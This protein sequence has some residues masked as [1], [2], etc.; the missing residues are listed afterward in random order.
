VHGGERKK[1]VRW[2][3]SCHVHMHVYVG[4]GVCVFALRPV[5]TTHSV[6]VFCSPQKDIKDIIREHCANVC[7]FH[8]VE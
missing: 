8:W 5:F 6:D 7:Y 3:V 2:V 1:G 4:V